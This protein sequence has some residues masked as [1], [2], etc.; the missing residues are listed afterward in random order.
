MEPESE[1]Q[2]IPVPG[3]AR[4]TIDPEEASFRDLL[5]KGD[6][7]GARRITTS[8]ETGKKLAKRLGIDRLALAVLIAC[9]ASLLVIALVTLFH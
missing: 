6:F 4:E 3:E 1:E 2:N 8:T 9:F 7:K 5:E